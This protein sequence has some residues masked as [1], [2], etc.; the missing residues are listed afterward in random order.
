MGHFE[1][2]FQ[3]EQLAD[4]IHWRLTA[5][6]IYIDDVLGKR[7]APVGFITDGGSIPLIAQGFINPY[8]KG[9]PAFVIHDWEYGT[10]TISR[11]EAD[12]LLKRMLSDCGENWLD[13]DIQFD[14]VR[15]GGASAWESDKPMIAANLALLKTEAA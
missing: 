12:G 6:M 13:D 10:Q 14:A 4:G 5:P 11:D 15:I 7:E 8:G 3:G 2:T 9:L 1:T